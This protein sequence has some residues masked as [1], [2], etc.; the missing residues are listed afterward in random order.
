MRDVHSQALQ[1]WV[2]GFVVA[3]GVRARDTS[4]SLV[5]AHHP[6]SRAFTR[7]TTRSVRLDRPG[8]RDLVHDGG[9]FLRPRP[10]VR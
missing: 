9:E 2:A 3:D 7:P 8:L 4:E 6:R 5:A 10:R 1:T